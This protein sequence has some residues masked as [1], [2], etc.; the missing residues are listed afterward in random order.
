MTLIKEMG[1]PIS[2]GN[3]ERFASEDPST[4]F[5]DIRKLETEA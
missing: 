2:F 3:H 5:N 4:P 1:K